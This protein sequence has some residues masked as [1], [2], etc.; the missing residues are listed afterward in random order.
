MRNTRKCQVGLPLLL[1]AASAALSCGNDPLSQVVVILGADETLGA[2]AKCLLV[3]VFNTASGEEEPLLPV[4][5]ELGPQSELPVRLPLSPEGNDAGRTYRI[6]AQLFAGEC[7]ASE[8]LGV[9]IVASGYLQNELRE[10]SVTFDSTCELTRCADGFR[11]HAG[12]CV[13]HCVVPR[14]RSETQDAELVPSDPASCASAC[15]SD[16]CLDDA[17]LDCGTDGYFTATHQCGFGCVPRTAEPACNELEPTNA[18][19]DFAWPT[20]LA[21]LEIDN[22]DA[23]TV[24]DPDTG[25]VVEIDKT[26]GA[27][28]AEL[29]A[30]NADPEQYEE[31]AGIGFQRVREEVLRVAAGVFVD[32]ETGF[33]MFDSLLVA[34]EGTL[35]GLGSGALSAQTAALVLLID[36]DVRI[37][38]EVSVAATPERPGPGG[39][40]GGG[41][42]FGCGDD[43]ADGCGPGGGAQGTSA[44]CGPSAIFSGGAGGSYGAFGGF[45]G[46]GVNPALCEAVPGADLG[47]T[48]GRQRLTVLVGG[49]GG[50][51]GRHDLGGIGGHGGG[52]LQIS[53]NGNL[54]VG[55]MGVITAGGGAGSN[56]TGSNASGGGAGGAVLLEAGQVHFEEP[57]LLDARLG[58]PGG[59]GGGG[60]DDGDGT[61]GDPRLVPAPGAPNTGGQAGSSQGAGGDGSSHD[62]R[63]FSG[64]A[65]SAGGGGGGG[66][67]RIRVNTRAGEPDREALLPFV[68]PRSDETFTVGEA[69]LEDAE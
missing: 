59:G 69:A 12:Q 37:F 48:Y 26:T 67:G 18:P 38:G 25:R 52:A 50:G 64:A 8:Q 23:E 54:W 58:A 47:S 49:S 41:S 35:R 40:V 61:P 46:D 39:F 53:T 7:E 65:G 3:R 10:I 24:F 20:G 9:Q 11:C 51:N 6:E 5:V 45:G 63:G 33:F 28:V 34:P 62:G 19:E 68:T 30:A 1:L 15:T 13:E 43:N 17:L 31:L 42:T 14:P 57:S 66:G 29:R 56:T 16:A 44:P 36:R 32:I 4:Q 27:E 60:G 22:P 2:Q 21:A 55:T